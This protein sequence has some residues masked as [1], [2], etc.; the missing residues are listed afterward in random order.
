MTAEWTTDLNSERK[1]RCQRA[2]NMESP[3][4]LIE[5]AAINY[6]LSA[7]RAEGIGQQFQA[8]ASWAAALPRSI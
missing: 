3:N 8:Y 6:H 7:H 4:V 2:L 1:C 5:Q